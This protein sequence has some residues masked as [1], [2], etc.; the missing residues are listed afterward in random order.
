MASSN[1]MAGFA[2]VLKSLLKTWIQPDFRSMERR[3]SFHF[4]IYIT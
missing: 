1:N 4:A 3:I 2:V